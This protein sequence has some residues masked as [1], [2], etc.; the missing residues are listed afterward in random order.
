MF[1]PCIKKTYTQDQSM[2]LD[3]QFQGVGENVSDKDSD[4]HSVYIPAITSPLDIE[5]FEYYWGDELRDLFDL[6]RQSTKK[7]GWRLF[8]RATF[9]DFVEYAYDQSSKDKPLD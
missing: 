8:E 1:K 9:A 6:L 7:Q 2:T 3:D 5:H 4:D